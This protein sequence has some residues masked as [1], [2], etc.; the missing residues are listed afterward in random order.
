MQAVVSDVDMPVIGGRALA[1]RLAAAYP[2]LPVLLTSGHAATELARLGVLPDQERT[3]LQK[4]F[5]PDLVVRVRG[6]VDGARAS[7]G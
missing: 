3:I 7:L 1:E 6:L 5:S 2:R 4:P